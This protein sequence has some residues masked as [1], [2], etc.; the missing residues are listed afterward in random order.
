MVLSTQIERARRVLV[1]CLGAV[2]VLV[3]GTGKLAADAPDG[4]STS[5]AARDDAIRSIPFDKLTDEMQARLSGVISNASIYRRLP[6]ETIGCDPDMYLFL[7]RYPEVVINI[8]DLMGVTNVSAKRVG[9]YMLDAFDGV[10]TRSRVELVYGTHD[11]H[12]LY[13]EGVYSGSLL[14]RNVR[15]RSVLV[16]QS[17]YAQL[18]DGSVRITNQLDVF[19]ELD[20][21]GA[22][23]FARTLQPLIGKSADHNFVEITSFIGRISEAAE[24]NGP[25]VQRMAANLQKVDPEVRQRFSELAATVYQ[26]AALRESALSAHSVGGP[27]V[28]SNTTVRANE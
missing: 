21:V 11:T 15:G 16:L 18:S 6:V 28:D 9:P 20:H 27:A 7:V 5:R 13:G 10:G 19:V 12:I 17:R 2:A 8:W 14:A 23:L 24:T 3:A 1:G 4:G 22:E 25:G 26:R